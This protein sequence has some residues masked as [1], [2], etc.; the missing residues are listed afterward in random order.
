MFSP[1]DKMVTVSYIYGQP[2]IHTNKEEY[3]SKTNVSHVEISDHYAFFWN[4]KINFGVKKSSHKS[5]TYRSFKYFNEEA[6]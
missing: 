6:F 3:V 2:R 4:R 5:I 1:F